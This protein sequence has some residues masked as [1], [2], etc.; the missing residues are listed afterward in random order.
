MALVW[1]WYC[2]CGFVCCLVVVLMTVGSFVIFAVG[3]VLCWFKLIVLGL[4]L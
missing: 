3:L 4:V 1:V 2:V